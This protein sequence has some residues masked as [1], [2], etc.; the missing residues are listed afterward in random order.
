[1]TMEFYS[2][3]K[4]PF[5]LLLQQQSTQ[6]CIASEPLFFCRHVSC[7]RTYIRPAPVFGKKKKKFKSCRI[8]FFFFFFF[9]LPSNLVWTAQLLAAGWIKPVNL[10]GKEKSLNYEETPKEQSVMAFTKHTNVSSIVAQPFRVQ[11]FLTVN[12][13][14]SRSRTRSIQTEL[15]EEAEIVLLLLLLLLL[16]F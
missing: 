9:F 5:N 13:D 3:V 1:M 4:R 11:N 14:Q 12:Q 10:A 6:Q 15:V 7:S 2:G 8:F 16:L